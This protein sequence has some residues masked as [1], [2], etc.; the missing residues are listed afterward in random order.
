MVLKLIGVILIICY[1]VTLDY[2]IQYDLI[3]SID[4]SSEGMIIKF[5]RDARTSVVSI[6][7][8]SEKTE[9]ETTDT[10]SRRTNDDDVDDASNS[11]THLPTISGV[12]AAQETEQST[13][14]YSNK[15]FAS[16]EEKNKNKIV[17]EIQQ[18]DYK[19]KTIIKVEHSGV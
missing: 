6:P 12:V 16:S 8:L 19:N 5:D 15:A 17:I 14:S 7:A 2:L 11:T 18:P 9:S 3:D 1:I 13:F 4:S 10:T